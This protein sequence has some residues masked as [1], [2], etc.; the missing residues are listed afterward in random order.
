MNAGRFD[1]LHD[2]ADDGGLPVADGIDIHFHGIF[3]KL[4]DEN[5]ISRRR[6]NGQTGEIL[7]LLTVVNDLHGPTAQYKRGA[8]DHRVA[9]LLG[10]PARFDNLHGDTVGRLDEP[11]L[12]EHGLELL[13][14]FCPIDAV[15]MRSQD[16]NAGIGQWRG[17]VQRRLAP[18]LD[19]HP[20]RLLFFN[21]VQHILFGQRLEVKLVGCIVIGRHGLGVRIDH[22][23]LN[24]FLSQGKRGVYAAIVKL[25]TLADPIGPTAQNHHLFLLRHPASH[26]SS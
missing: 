10:N 9:D 19:D 5:G 24:P 16:G 17:Q 21:N 12:F 13:A 8:H 15:G 23:A 14:I 26:S 2:P 22:D 4:V 25:N 6:K 11:Q 3:Q 7:Q 20:I 1:M 18:K